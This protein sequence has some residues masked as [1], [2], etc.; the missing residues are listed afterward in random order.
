MT[1]LYA[2]LSGLILNNTE[3]QLGHGVVLRR[4]YAYLFASNMIAFS[5]ATPGQAHPGPWKSARGGFAHEIT[6]ELFIPEDTTNHLGT[7]DA[8][9]QAVAFTLRLGVDPATSLA[10]L[11]NRP[12]AADAQS[13][14]QDAWITSVEVEARRFSLTI[15]NG[16]PNEVSARLVADR[17]PTLLRFSKESAE[18]ALIVDALNIGQYIHRSALT[19]VSLWAALEALFSPSN[20]ELKFRVSSLIAAYLEPPGELRRTRAIAVGKLYDKRSSAAHGKPN[21]E[22]AHVVDSFNLARE[23]LTKLLD[24]KHIPTKQELERLLYGSALE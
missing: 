11:S 18:F 14:D 6:A 20:S 10:V 24:E 22:T 3:L 2:G 5:P 23:I 7:T 12:L 8:I 1:D 9:A 17:W 4:T 15:A 21:H 13:S 16:I 19:I